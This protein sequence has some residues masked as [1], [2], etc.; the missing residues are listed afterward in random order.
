[1]TIYCTSRSRLAIAALAATC[2]I[3][4]LPAAAQSDDDEAAED[5][6]RIEEVVVT[7]TRRETNIMETPFA[8]QVFG[9]DQLEDENILHHR[10]LYEHIP[11]ITYKDNAQSD[12][13]AQMRGSG[14]TSVGGEDGAPAIGTYI[15]DAPWINITSQIPDSSAHRLFRRPTHRGPARPSGYQ[16]WPGRNRRLDTCLHP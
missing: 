13:T 5:G 7:A 2:T 3:V 11:G 9:G 10:D 12:V 4:G 8:M 6:S 14:I 16:L 1:M 15:D